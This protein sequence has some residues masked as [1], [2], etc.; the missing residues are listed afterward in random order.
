MIAEAAFRPA[1]PIM[2]KPDRFKVNVTAAPYCYY[3]YR[4]SSTVNRCS[5]NGIITAY[6]K[7]IPSPD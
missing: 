5:I 4:V 6:G 2:V 7:G 1:S 3:H